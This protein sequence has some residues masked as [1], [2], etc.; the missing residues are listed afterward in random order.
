MIT[1]ARGHY[2][3][4]S[5]GVHGAVAHAFAKRC[6]PGITGITARGGNAS[7]DGDDV[8][9]N[10]IQLVTDRTACQSP[11]I[12]ECVECGFR[13]AISKLRNRAGGSCRGPATREFSRDTWP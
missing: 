1:R 12:D 5:D 11:R 2:G 7:R 13:A 3:C 10:D 6:P 8:W 4:V 9:V